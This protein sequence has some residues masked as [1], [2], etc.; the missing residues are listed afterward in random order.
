MKYY[1]AIHVNFYIVSTSFQRFTWLRQKKKL[2][3]VFFSN[4]KYS[5]HANRC[6]VFFF[7]YLVLHLVLLILTLNRQVLPSLTVFTHGCCYYGWVNNNAP[8]RLGLIT[9]CYTFFFS[10]WFLQKKSNN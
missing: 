3:R 2:Y 4:G 8:G 9:D 5:L 7:I 6:Y 10:T 1:N